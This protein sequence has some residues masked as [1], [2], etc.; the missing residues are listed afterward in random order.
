MLYVDESVFMG[1]GYMTR[2][3]HVPNNLA[4]LGTWTLCETQSLMSKFHLHGKVPRVF[5]NTSITMEVCIISL[6]E[7]I[8]MDERKE[9]IFVVLALVMVIKHVIDAF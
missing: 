6:Q 2:G 7:T 9:H 3:I 5:W 4:S 1:Y 8:A